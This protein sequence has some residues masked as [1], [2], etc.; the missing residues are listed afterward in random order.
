MREAL[1]IPLAKAEVLTRLPCFR[2]TTTLCSRHNL[3]PFAYFVT[4]TFPFKREHY[5]SSALDTKT[6]IKSVQPKQH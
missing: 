3:N 1:T 2:R 4:Y 5:L 6:K